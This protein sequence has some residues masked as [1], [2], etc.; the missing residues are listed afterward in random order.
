MIA[1]WA[2]AAALG[3]A[4]ALTAVAAEQPGQVW[5]GAYSGQKKFD[6]WIIRDAR[7]WE[8]LWRQLEMPPPREFHPLAE[9][10]VVV[11]LGQRMTG[12]YGIAFRGVERYAGLPMVVVIEEERPARDAFVTAALTTPYWVGVFPRE[13]GLIGVR[14]AD[15]SRTVV[16]V[17]G[18]EAYFAD[19]ARRE[20]RR[21]QESLVESLRACKAGEIA[22]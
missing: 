12:G 5:Q 3:A 16:A 18:R 20:C 7:N 9:T 21:N 14:F 17:P 10:A 15:W 1:G 19:R 22:R 13:E 2:F 8:G 4:V 11:L 6:V